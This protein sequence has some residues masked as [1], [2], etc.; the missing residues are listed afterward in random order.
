MILRLVFGSDWAAEG[1]FTL[2]A[3]LF[4]F[5]GAQFVALG[6]LGEYLGRV[7]DQVRQRPRYVVRSEIE[8][9]SEAR[10]ARAAGSRS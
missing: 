9:V 8:T 6:I 7:Y 5:V 1:V 2:F 10:P 3:V 4:A